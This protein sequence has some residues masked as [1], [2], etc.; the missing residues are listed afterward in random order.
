MK[1][2][3]ILL[4]ILFVVSI[5]AQNKIHRPE[6]TAEEIKANVFYLASDAMKGR[7]TGSPEERKA[8]DYIKNEFQLYG[9]KP[10]FKENWFQE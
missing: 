8:G 9:L 1:R 6:I 3:L 4:I 2:I 7:F 5:Q 10:A